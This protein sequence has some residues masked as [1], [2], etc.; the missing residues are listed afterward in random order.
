A[1]E[2]LD[3]PEFADVGDYLLTL[4]AG[5]T[6][7]AHNA[8]FDMRFLQR[9]LQRAKYHLPDRPPALCSM[10]WAGRVIG[11]AKLEHCCEALDIEL[12]QAHTAL[13]DA[14]ATAQLLGFLQQRCASSSEW[15][16]DANISATFSWPSL[17]RR[18]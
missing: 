16:S 17:S 11:A 9:E 12:A 5:R 15:R 2:L 8:P 6:V 14:R 1:A 3:A 13:A 18:A 7:V 4:L 10:K